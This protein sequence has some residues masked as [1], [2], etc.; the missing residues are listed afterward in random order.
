MCRSQ[1][2]SSQPQA[3]KH[4]SR[5]ADPSRTP[6]E[7]CMKGANSGRLSCCWTRR[8]ENPVTSSASPNSATPEGWTGLPLR[9]APCPRARGR[10]SP[11]QGRTPRPP[12]AYLRPTGRSISR[13][14]ASRGRSSWCRRAGLHARC[15]PIGQPAHHLPRPQWH[16]QGTRRSG[17]E[18]SL[19]RPGCRTRSPAQPTAQRRRHSPLQSLRHNWRD[20]HPQKLNDVE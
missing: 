19:S 3:T 11:R 8:W 10:S 20:G 1:N 15:G 2:P 4:R 14:W 12:Q 18:Q 6:C 5:A 9:K 16:H 13:R 7:A 17:L